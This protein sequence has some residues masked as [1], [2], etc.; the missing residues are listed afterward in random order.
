L[1][2]Q[3][4]NEIA[5]MLLSFLTFPLGGVVRKLEGNS[6]VGSIDALYNSIVD[7]NENYFMSKSA[8]N[9]LV[10]PYLLLLMS[11]ISFETSKTNDGNEKEPRMFVVTDDLVVTQSSPTSDL[12]LDS[13]SLDLKEKVVAIGLVEVIVYV[14]LFLFLCFEL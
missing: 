9:R 10:D 14:V 5:N 7:M 1:Y 4:G 3:G 11:L 13:S 2:A 6:C 12:N 8:K